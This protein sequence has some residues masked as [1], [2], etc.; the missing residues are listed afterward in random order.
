MTSPSLIENILFFEGLASLL[1]VFL[2]IV[3][4][5]IR[6]RHVKHLFIVESETS[7]KIGQLFFLLLVLSI[8][9]TSVVKK[10]LSWTVVPGIGIDAFQNGELLARS[11]MIAGAILCNI[12]AL[13]LGW[14]LNSLGHN[15]TN[16][17]VV[18]ERQTLVT[19][20][21]YKW[22]RHP[23]TLSTFVITIGSFLINGNWMVLLCMSFHWLWGFKKIPL[24]EKVLAE[25]FGQVFQVYKHST[26]AF[27]PCLR[28]SPMHYLSSAYS[29]T[30][31][32]S[33]P[34][35]VKSVLRNAKNLHSTI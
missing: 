4:F 32:Q 7:I 31:E 16:E 25:I 18:V 22:V 6:N 26:P 9:I 30:D 27:I 1:M 8:I 34:D 21:A 2:V 14:S 24:E 13:S 20:G 15:W 23:V 29:E 12:G 17:V 5:L 10:S 3:F 11:F 19:R 35:E 28:A 33:I